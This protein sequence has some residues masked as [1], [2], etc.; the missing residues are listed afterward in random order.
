VDGSGRVLMIHC[1]K[2]LPTHDLVEHLLALPLDLAQAMYGEGGYQAQLYVGVGKQEYQ[3]G[4]GFDDGRNPGDPDRQAWP[5]P[6]VV[7]ARPR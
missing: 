2:P 4:G 1:R 7:A 3:F 6:N 5:L